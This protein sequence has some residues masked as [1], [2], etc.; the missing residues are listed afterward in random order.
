MADHQFEFFIDITPNGASPDIT[1]IQRRN[2]NVRMTRSWPACM[3]QAGKIS[4]EGILNKEMMLRQ[5]DDE[6]RRK[7]EAW[8]IE[9]KQNLIKLL[10]D[11]NHHP[12]LS[13][14][15]PPFDFK[16]LEALADKYTIKQIRE[17]LNEI[18]IWILAGESRENYCRTLLS[19]M[20]RKYEK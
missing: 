17:C 13:K 1:H 4:A 10:D 15:N 16:F 11:I 19:W 14:S 2:P 7:R 20:K 5:I 6:K 9:H 3:M 18:H 8:Q 12:S